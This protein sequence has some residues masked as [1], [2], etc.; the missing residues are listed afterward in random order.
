[1]DFSKHT[2]IYVGLSLSCLLLYFV[3][4][5]ILPVSIMEARNYLVSR[6][7]L[8]DGNWILTTMN[9][10]ARYQKP[11]LPSWIGAALVGLFNKDHLLIHR[12]AASLMATAS[13][14]GMYGLVRFYFKEAFFSFVAAA[15]FA[16]SLYV[17]LIRFEAPSDVFTHGFTV[18]AILYLSKLV[19]SKK[20]QFGSLILGGLFLSASV[21]AKGPVSLYALF[22][23]FTI[24]CFI[25]YRK[26]VKHYFFK[27]LA[28]LIGGIGIGGVWYLYVRYADPETFLKVAETET[29]NWSSYNVRPFYYYWSFFIQSGYWAILAL[30]SLAY[31]YFKNRVAFKK[32]Y[33]WSFLWTVLS[34][35]LL[36][37]IPEKKSRY[38][39]P[40][41]FPLAINTAVIL[42]YIANNLST[43]LSKT[44]LKTYFFVSLIPVIAVLAS[45][46]FVEEYSISYFVWL[47]VFVGLQVWVLRYGFISYQKKQSKAVILSFLASAILIFSIGFRGISFAPKNSAYRPY[48]LNYITED[49][50]ELF[51]FEAIRPE[52]LFVAKTKI[53]N[54]DKINIQSHQR[55]RILVA[56]PNKE[57]LLKKMQCNF[58]IEKVRE[59]D[60]NIYGNPDSKSHKEELKLWEYTFQQD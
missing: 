22:L 21:M 57:E 45:S 20:W 42:H 46:Y 1:M 47:I 19:F 27:V 31:P 56:E 2:W 25:V 12:L 5:D 26:E 8:T 49:S 30:V 52:V 58:K 53:P 48:T 11:P 9:G 34:V 10:E 28:V 32:V 14:F 29:G 44:L 13:V 17:S 54:L 18:F 36:S 3:T 41:L 50:A 38:L 60:N 59:F 40:V 43:K 23:P 55:L 33:L 15:V 4:I 37:V 16:S 7:M 24:A 35:V 51:H 39:Y 6:E